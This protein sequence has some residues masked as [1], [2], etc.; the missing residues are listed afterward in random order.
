[1]VTCILSL[2]SIS[3]T[4]VDHLDADLHLLWE[5]GTHSLTTLVIIIHCC[6]CRSYTAY[7]YWLNCCLEIL[8]KK[9]GNN[10]ALYFESKIVHEGASHDYASSTRLNSFS[11][12]S[13]FIFNTC[14]LFR[15]VVSF[16]SSAIRLLNRWDALAPPTSS[17]W[18]SETWRDEQSAWLRVCSIVRGT[19]SIMRCEFDQAHSAPSIGYRNSESSD[20]L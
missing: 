11:V 2:A 20:T 3:L 9:C 1:M 4:L 5:V 7:N 19:V 10:G 14:N 13:N 17:F 8:P 12:L 15:S 18:K 6:T 16:G